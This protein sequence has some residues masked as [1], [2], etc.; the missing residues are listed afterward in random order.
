M[1]KEIL[2]LNHV[3]L[4]ENG[5]RYLDNLD[6]YILQGEIMGLIIS[7]IIFP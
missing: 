5:E 2:R 4:E 7:A 3:T 1:R 6:F